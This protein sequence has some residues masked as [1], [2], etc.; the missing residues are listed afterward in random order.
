MGRAFCIDR[1]KIISTCATQQKI[2]LA[3]RLH[4]SL[5]NIVGARHPPRS[6]ATHKNRRNTCVHGLCKKTD[7]LSA[8]HK[9]LTLH[10]KN[11]VCKECNSDRHARTIAVRF[12]KSIRTNC[13]IRLQ[14]PNKSGG[15]N[16]VCHCSLALQMRFFHSN[17]IQSARLS[18]F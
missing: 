2:V 4:H 3:T 12:L 8:A 6:C 11:A 9:K 7:I 1:I 5:P 10:Q 17:C 18:I 15:Y 16:R 13:T 14:N